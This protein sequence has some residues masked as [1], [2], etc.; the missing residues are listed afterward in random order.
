M[1]PTPRSLIRIWPV[2]RLAVRH[3]DK[4]IGRTINLTSSIIHSGG[5]KKE[6]EPRGCRWA[7]NDPKSYLILLITILSQIGNDS[8]RLIA[9]CLVNLKM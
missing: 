6:G 7:R 8:A 5:F 9:R 1:N 2:L 4:V 3:T